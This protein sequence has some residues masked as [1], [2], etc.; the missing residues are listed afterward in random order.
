MVVKFLPKFTS[1]MSMKNNSKTT[2]QEQKSKDP[3]ARIFTNTSGHVVEI[4]HLDW[5]RI[6][7]IFD[8]DDFSAIPHDQLAYAK[9]RNS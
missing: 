6:Y 8:N 4:L 2:L 5:S 1:K 7:S 3:N 9:I